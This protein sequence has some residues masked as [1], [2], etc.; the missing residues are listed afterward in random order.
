MIRP[1]LQ[2]K[3]KSCSKYEQGVVATNRG[4]YWQQ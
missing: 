4:S 1:D 3:G 2:S